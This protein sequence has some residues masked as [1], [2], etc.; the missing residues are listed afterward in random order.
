MH[1]CQNR[2]TIGSVVANLFFS[3]A[4]FYFASDIHYSSRER[5]FIYIEYS[6]VYMGVK[7]EWQPGRRERD[8]PNSKGYLSAAQLRVAPALHDGLHFDPFAAQES[9]GLWLSAKEVHKHVHAV[10]RASVCQDLG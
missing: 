6:I 7:V 5:N 2:V 10:F 9:R 4:K 8:V 3:L 1:N